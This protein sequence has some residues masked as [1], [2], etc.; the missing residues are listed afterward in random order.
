MDYWILIEQEIPDCEF[1]IEKINKP[2][3]STYVLRECMDFF[4]E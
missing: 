3:F 1:I 4:Y 2:R